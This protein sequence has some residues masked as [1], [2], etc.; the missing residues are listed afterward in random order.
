MIVYRD[1]ILVS[2]F[3]LFQ[4]LFTS[5]FF[6]FSLYLVNLVCNVRTKSLLVFAVVGWVTGLESSF[7]PGLLLGMT[8]CVSQLSPV[9]PVDLSIFSSNLAGPYVYL[10]FDSSLRPI[11][12]ANLGC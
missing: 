6:P 11:L 1:K 12:L 2:F 9:S 8:S 4:M 7:V 10:G 3:G 5:R